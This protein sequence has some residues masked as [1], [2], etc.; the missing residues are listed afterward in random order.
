[1][2]MR[3]VGLGMFLAVAAVIALGAGNHGIRGGHIVR[4]AIV[5][6]T[7]QPYA[8]PIL[9]WRG[10]SGEVLTD[11]AAPGVFAIACGG[12]DNEAA[13]SLLTETAENN[14]KTGKAIFG[15]TLPPEYVAGQAVVVRFYALYE[16]VTGTP[17]VTAATIDIQLIVVSSDGDTET[18]EDFAL[19]NL[20]GTN[21]AKTFASTDTTLSP[22]DGLVV[23]LRC[24]ITEGAGSVG[25]ARLRVYRPE[26][27]LTVKG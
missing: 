25:T 17:D 26:I 4:A 15:F 18:P 11:T 27:L 5:S 19:Q 13:H 8:L 22:G 10:E 12:W 9:E 14:E 16:T 20:T 6:Q 3:W 23:K 21:A 1:M 2:R 24:A 7:N